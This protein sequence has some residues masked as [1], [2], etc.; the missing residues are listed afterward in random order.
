MGALPHLSREPYLRT[1]RIA[2]TDVGDTAGCERYL[3]SAAQ[4]KGVYVAIGHSPLA[5]D[6]HHSLAWPSHL[7][8]S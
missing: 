7:P 1:V 3:L 5:G 2:L 6:L 8:S 4:V